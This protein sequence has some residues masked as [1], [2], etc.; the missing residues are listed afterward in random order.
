MG[1]RL[2][3]TSL[4]IVVACCLMG[5]GL[6]LWP[7]PARAAVGE[8][9]LA[10]LVETSKAFTLIAREVTPTVVF[11][12]VEQTVEAGRSGAPFEFNNPFDQY[13]EEF[14]RR[15]FGDRLP[16]PQRPREYK[17]RGWG[18]GFI[19]SG[20]G[21]I[22]TNHHVVGGA[23]K[24]SVRLHDGRELDANLVG[25]DPKSDVAIIKVNEAGDL[26]VLALGDSDALQVGEWVMAI[27]NPFGLSHTVTVGVVSAK[28]RTSMGITDYEDF[29]QTDAAINP[30]NSGGPLI[31]MRG[32]AVGLNSAIF[33][34]SGGYMGIGFAIPINMVKAIQKQLIESGSVARGFLGVGIQDLTKELVESFGLKDTEGV[35]VSQVYEDSP[36]ARAGIQR[37]D[38]VVEYEGRKVVNVGQFRNMVALTAPKTRVNLVVLRE[39][40]RNELTVELGSIEKDAPATMGRG[41][42]MKKLGFSVQ[43][44]TDELAQQ[45][46]YEAG[47]GV[48]VTEVEPRSPAQEAGMRQGML[49]MEVN[50]KAVKTTQDFFEALDLSSESKRVLILLRDRQMSRYLILQVP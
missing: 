42:T 11:I 8:K 4:A 50:R 40:K 17:Q 34:R 36:A 23:D 14:F 46:G 43:D 24:I 1:L 26:P 25:T 21:Y 10:P 47:E 16:R 9:D 44:L 48:L 18:S 13:N 41:E 15:F 33:T 37:G 45:L 28:G 7:A 22:L 2:R 6:F 35:L 27:G 32:E 29:I 20:D 30:G 31:N 5:I 19:I 3:Q 49:I 38:V 39:G 12:K